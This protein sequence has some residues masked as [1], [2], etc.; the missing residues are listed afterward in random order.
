MLE[1]GRRPLAGGDRDR[2]LVGEAAVA[3]EVVGPQRRLDE[4]ELVALP[5]GHHAQRRVGVGEGVL[6]VDEQRDVGAD[7]AADGRQHLGAALP[8]LD[9]AGVGVG[10]GERDLGA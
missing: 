10:A 2:L 9:E 4:G 5:V 3:G 6:D 7:R 8:R 1:A